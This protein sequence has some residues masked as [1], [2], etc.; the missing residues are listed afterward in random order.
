[1]GAIKLLCI[2]FII[3]TQSLKLVSTRKEDADKVDDGDVVPKDKL[4]GIGLGGSIK[5]KP[6]EPAQSTEKK[7]EGKE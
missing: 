1:M 2:L 5:G 7:E 3:H 6:E 4:T